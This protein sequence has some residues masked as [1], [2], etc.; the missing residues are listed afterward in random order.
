M[1]LSHMK[2]VLLGM[3]GT[4][5]TAILERYTKGTFHHNRPTIGSAFASKKVPAGSSSIIMGLWDTCGQEKF[6]SLCR[7]YYQ[8][9]SAAIVCYDLT[10]GESFTKAQHWIDELHKLNTEDCAIYLIGTKYDLIENGSARGISPTKLKQFAEGTRAKTM[11]T[12]SKT[13]YNIDELF[14]T[15]AN[16]FK[17]SRKR[18]TK[19]GEANSFKLSSEDEISRRKMC[20]CTSVPATEENDPYSVIETN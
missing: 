12:S 19:D 15:I 10:N 20:S 1:A 18:K 14:S 2:V 9:A 11:E 4:G 16:D 6:Q 7:I 3:T 17:S 5:K 8:G 13:G